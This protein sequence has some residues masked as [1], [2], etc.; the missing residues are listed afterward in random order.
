MKSILKLVLFTL[1][2]I[3][4]AEGEFNYTDQA[5]WNNLPNS[6]CGKNS[7]SPIVLPESEFADTTQNNATIKFNGSQTTSISK[8]ESFKS[9]G[10]F[11]SLTLERE[12][13]KS[14]FEAL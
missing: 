13:V 5:A 1:F 14:E 11:A 6:E 7:Q 9:V 8:S 10:N 3:N 4:A 2:S 12:G